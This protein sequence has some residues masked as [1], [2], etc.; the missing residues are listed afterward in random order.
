MSIEWFR[1]WH[2][3]PTDNKWLVIA[4]RSGAPAG[5]VSAVVWALFDYASQ[6]ENRGSVDGFDVETYATFS[7]FE[8]AKIAAIITALEEKSV[9]VSGILSAWQ[10]RQ[11]KREDNSTERVRQHRNAMKRD[12]TQGNAR[13]DKE[14]I[15][16]EKKD[17]GADAP[18][19]EKFEDFWKAYPRRAGANPKAPAEK[20]FVAAVKSGA[21]PADII[22][23][24]KRCAVVDAGKIN[25]EYIPQAVKWLR[26][27]RW[28]DYL[29]ADPPAVEDYSVDWEEKVSRFKQGHAWSAKWYGPEPGQIGCRV[30]PEILSKYGFAEQAA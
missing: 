20:L 28:R 18:R 1:S 17:S 13:V 25:T 21:D 8:E 12:E 27:K 6:N 22:A 5:V 15:R 23:G 11:P 4:K 3:A 24:A 19:D 26:D 16:E 9:I 29:E 7:G 10:K 14:E 30:P 2:G